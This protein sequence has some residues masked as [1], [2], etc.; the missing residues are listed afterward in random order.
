MQRLFLKSLQI[1]KLNLRFFLFGAALAA[2][3]FGLISWRVYEPFAVVSAEKMNTLYIGVDNPITAIT[4]HGAVDID[5]ISVSGGT[6]T[7]DRGRFVVSVSRVGD[8]TITIKKNGVKQSFPFNI[9]KIPDPVLVLGAGPS[10]RGGIMPL[11][12]FKAQR[13]ISAIL[14]SMNFDAKCSVASY[15]I[16]RESRGLDPEKIFNEGG[17]YGKEASS[18]IN[19]ATTGDRYTYL[20]IKARCTGDVAARDM[21]SIVITIK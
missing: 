3:I 18:L 8:C 14:E 20:Y 11:G 12:E 16:V 13:G 2:I 10:K 9:K 19:K 1:Q 7:G 6:I 5:S 15:S 4:T 21:G 17:T